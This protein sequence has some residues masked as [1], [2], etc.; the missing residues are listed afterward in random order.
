MWRLYPEVEGWL[1]FAVDD[2][3]LMFSLQNIDFTLLL[4]CDAVDR[5][6]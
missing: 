1:A 6:L 4:W 5:E 3:F 2:F